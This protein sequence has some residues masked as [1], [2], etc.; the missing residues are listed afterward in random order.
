MTRCIFDPSFNDLPDEIPVFPLSGVLLL[1]GG[2]LP[3]NIFEPRYLA[4]IDAALAGDR[5]I[6]MVQ[7]SEEDNSNSPL[8]PDPRQSGLPDC[9]P[10]YETG[11]AGR[12]NAF[13]ETD[14]GRYL[15]T[16]A[17][18][19]RFEIAA[20]LELE[21]GFRRVTAD[22]QRFQGDLTS[23]DV[24]IDRDHLLE[25]V[26]GY[27]SSQGIRGDWEAIGQTENEHLVTSLAMICP[28]AASEKQLLLEA[29]TLKE[30]AETM[31]KI[32]EMAIHQPGA[33]KSSSG[34]STH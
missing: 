1:P 33:D 2:H 15:I 21:N 6:G 29:M 34:F 25:T 28:F 23:N 22:Y 20:E 7:P 12:I 24:A 32:M 30:R 19:I 13:S 27:F 3:L 11:C 10:I 26:R 14:D 18:L 5:I 8:Q 17:G 16:L 9:P 4:M 31:T